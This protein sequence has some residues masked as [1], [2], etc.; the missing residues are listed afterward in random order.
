MIPSQSQPSMLSSEV[1]T[2]KVFA[3]S[4]SVI[5]VLLKPLLSTQIIRGC[6]LFLSPFIVIFFKRDDG[7]FMG[8]E[9]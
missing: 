2:P 8:W 3:E 6:S 9:Q 7:H 4:T 1:W 5:P